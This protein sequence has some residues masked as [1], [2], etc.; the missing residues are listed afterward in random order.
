MNDILIFFQA[1]FRIQVAEIAASMG[2]AAKNSR[3]G[4]V[5]GSR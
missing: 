4:E 3:L 2:Q 5:Q 1:E